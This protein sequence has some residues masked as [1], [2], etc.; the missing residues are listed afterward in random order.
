MDRSRSPR[1]GSRPLHAIAVAGV[2]LVTLA[3]TCKRGA[4]NPYSTTSSTSGTTTGA[5][6]AGGAGPTVDPELGGPCVDDSEC[7]DNI[8]CTFDACDKT[9][10]RCRFKP[11]D[12]LCQNGIYCDG[13]EKCDQ[14][15]GCVA[16]TPIDCG[17]NVDTCMIDTCVEQTQSCSHVLRDADGDG[18]PDIHCGGGDC[19]DMNPLVNS[20]VPE[21]CGNG[22]DDNCNGLIDEMPCVSP[23]HDKCNDPLN[24]SA[25]GSYAMSTLGAVPDY[26][27]SCSPT[28]MLR[29][30]VAAIL[31]PAGPP[32]DVIVSATSQPDVSVAIAGQCGMP[33]TE[34]ACGGSF[35]APGGH[36]ARL[37]AHSLGS[38]AQAM[39][40]PLYVTTAGPGADVTLAV[41]F[42]SP[43]PPPT[44]ETCGTALPITPGTPVIA[45]L[46]NATLDAKSACPQASGDLLYSFTLAAPSDIDVYATSTD[47]VSA[48]TISLRDTGCALPTD[49]IACNNGLPAHLY[50]RALAAGTYFIAISGSAPDTVSL[51]LELSAP[52]TPPADET[53]VGSPVLTPGVTQNVPLDHHQK[54][55]AL[56]CLS[57]GVDAAYEIDLPVASDVLVVE[58][59]S[60]GDYAG[61]ELSKAACA[62]TADRLTCNLGSTSPVLSGKR[63]VLA[64]SYRAIIDSSLGD[65]VQIT[66]WTRPAA[67]AVIV[68]FADTCPD[69]A[70][71]PETGGFFQG[72]TA[73]ATP[74]YTAGCDA[75]NGTPLGAPDQV[76]RLDLSTQKRVIFDMSGSGYSTL[77]DIRQGPACP[78]DEVVL[79]CSVATGSSGAPKSFLDLTLDA[80]TY[81]VIV[82]GLAGDSGPWFLSVFTAAP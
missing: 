31:L 14:K 73:N 43:T 81:F 5:G 54:D 33:G 2:V 32:V 1:V 21:V 56:G 46:T 44:N 42:T 77:L 52:T 20:K 36:V 78:G 10:N 68:P 74:N 19:D 66:A 9:L 34:I 76:L 67:P 15:L 80:G 48:P 41:S 58:R 30:V 45:D 25:P 38:P 70:V 63:N 53:C 22:I 28:G 79:G 71:I 62:T 4:P 61:I 47:G 8:P 60:S 17:T 39:A 37:H 65:P 16:G 35:V 12:S 40:Y 75:S 24:I 11:D 26:A 13:L 82:K 57:G 49:E 27:T 59:T 23:A 6:G 51:D 18:D 29:D 69:A 72:N 50:R 64:G 7:N 55:M 3:A